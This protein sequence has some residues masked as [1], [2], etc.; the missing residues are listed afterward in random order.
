MS[1]YIP[2]IK[3]TKWID[4]SQDHKKLRNELEN[5]ILKACTKREQM[6][7]IML[8]GAF[9][10]GKTNSLYYAFHYG[11]CE[12][13]T[14][15]FLVTLDEITKLVKESASNQQTGKIQN[16]Q[17]G[18]FLNKILEKQ[19]SVLK[20]KDWANIDRVYFP[21]FNGGDLTKY[22]ED[23]KQVEIIEDS[24]THVK[25]DVAFSE[26]IIKEAINSNNR[27][28]L[29]IDEFESK[30]Y[31]LKKYIETS[32]GGVLRELFD[33]IVQDTSL[34]YLIIGN[35]PASGYEIAKERG[36][37]NADSGTAEK[38]RLKTKPI[39]F[40]TSNLLKRSF[41]KD[42]PKGYINFIWWLS[43]CRP[44]HILK[45]RDSLGAI[46]DLKIL[47]FN[48]LIT[49][50]IFR[51]PIDEGGEAVTY[52]KTQF[53]NEVNGRIQ[54]TILGKVLCEFQPIEFDVKDLKQDLRECVYY[55]LCSSE[56]I[57]TETDLLPVLHRDLYAVHLKKYQEEGK[58]DSVNYIE[59]IQPYFSYI[60]SGISDLDGNIAFGM[61]NDSKAGEIL[62]STF[63]I[64]LLE[65]T[66]DFISLY[67]DDSVKETRDSLDFLLHL[68]NAINK[69]QQEDNLEVFVQ[70]T[71]DLFE[72]CKLLKKEK[73]HIQLSLYAIR[74]SV[75]QPIGSPK[76]KYKNEQVS[77]LLSSISSNSVLP[78]IFY[79]EHN[80][81]NYF[82]P[83]LEEELLNKYLEGLENHLYNLF[84]EEFHKDGQVV[85]RVIYFD[86]NDEINEFRINLLYV[87][88]DSSQQEAIY[89]LHKIDVV[90]FETYQLNFGGQIKDFI[91]SVCQIALIAYSR[92]EPDIIKLEE[93]GK[94]DLKKIIKIVG[95]RPWTEKKET[96]RTI[97]HYRKLLFDGENSIFKSIH[98]IANGDY[99][100]KLEGAVGNKDEFLDNVSEYYHLNQIIGDEAESYDKFTVDLALLYLFE[101]KVIDESLKKLL[102]LCKSDYHFNVD[103]EDASKAVNYKNL[104]SILTKNNNALETHLKGFDIESSFISKLSKFTQLL[105]REDKIASIGEYFSYLKGRPGNSFIESY[106]NS[107]GAY[108][109]P[110]L[111]ETLYNLNYL[112]DIPISDV[113]TA[114]TNELSKIEN[115]LSKV[116]ADI[117]TKIGELQTILDERD[118]LSSY[119]KKLSKAITGIGLMKTILA[120][121][122]SLSTLLIIAS[123]LKHFSKVVNDSSIFSDQLKDVYDAISKQ[124]A[125]ID[126]IQEEIDQLYED[127]LINKLLGFKY[128]PPRNNGY[129][130]RESYLPK[131][132]NT[133]DYEKLFGKTGNIYNPYLSSAIHS[134]KLEKF[135][136]CL[137]TIREGLKT[138]F[139]NLLHEMIEVGKT[140]KSTIQLKDFI[141]Q[142]LM[143]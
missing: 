46:E 97:E 33:Q 127:A 44:G 67:Q 63:L 47:S 31:E 23:F 58:F 71:F 121:E 28:L 4:L 7:P 25:F 73:V 62:A 9:G 20:E 102:E 37:T 1:V 88:G 137:V 123:V 59:H 122:P 60:L 19:I 22:L 13:K 94:I 14:P 12:L 99:R 93:N 103:R 65:L 128:N 15:T 75:E 40:P 133:E 52:L 119:A 8:Q 135:R 143:P 113:R 76:L 42:D 92:Q 41:L 96:I 3:T 77:E 5:D 136:N 120:K 51:E 38:R 85:I 117:T 78:I 49:N 36:D 16:D 74:E 105:I 45:L 53:F 89:S 2:L 32:G 21:E 132:K 114:I 131:L 101:N 104:L 134:D 34:F 126:I 26:D 39:P 72:K 109:L 17:L 95:D 82:I 138:E 107:L 116:R 83:S 43:R 79:K 29:L 86:P 81:Y 50:P 118:S 108:L 129:L 30:F 80:L 110:E 6:Q 61:I 98:K 111:T 87:N 18:P 139:D 115:S 48:E 90:N 130:W 56:I 66:Y 11:W 68:I 91:D 112:K 124:K 69:S 140:A 142:L 55:F 106:H 27:P 141:T 100:V 70:N 125:N 35:G 57:N 10:I 54:A 84:Y 64:P 24:Q